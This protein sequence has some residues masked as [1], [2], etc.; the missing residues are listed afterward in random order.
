MNFRKVEISNRDDIHSLFNLY[1]VFTF[2]RKAAEFINQMAAEDAHYCGYTPAS[3][4]SY[5]ILGAA[6]P[7]D[8]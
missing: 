3:D 4:K 5:L 1:W 6:L 2:I 8:D 7:L